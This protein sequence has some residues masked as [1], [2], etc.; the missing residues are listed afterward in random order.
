MEDKKELIKKLQSAAYEAMAD[1]VQ[2]P[3]EKMVGQSF[4]F[5]I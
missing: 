4:D 5:S 1:N 2:T 3:Q